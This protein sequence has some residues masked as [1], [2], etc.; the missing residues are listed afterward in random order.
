VEGPWWTRRAFARESAKMRFSTILDRWDSGEMTQETAAGLL[1]MSRSLVPTMEGAL[2][3]AW[4]GGTGRSAWEPLAA[5]VAAAGGGRAV[6]GAA[7]FLKSG[8]RKFPS[9]AG[10]R[11][12]VGVIRASVFWR[13]ADSST[14]RSG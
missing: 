10:W 14:P 1:G 8:A 4:R 5:A 9:Q 6:N 11:S 7:V 13:S 2:R 3:G 12:A